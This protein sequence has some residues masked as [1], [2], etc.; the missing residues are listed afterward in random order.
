MNIHTMDLNLFLVFR[1]I[2]ETGSVTL[3]GDRVGL[4]QSAASNALR[5]MRERFGDPLFVRTPGGMVPTALAQRLIGPV[6][7]GLGKLAQ[8]LEE[9]AQFD[10]A[11]S[12]RTF[13]I[14]INDIG[15]LVMM[16]RLLAAANQA[17]PGVRFETVDAKLAE[18]RHAMVHGQVD[19]AVGS[20]R[21]M[22]PTF[23]QQRLFDETFV[24]LMSATHPL[25]GRAMRFEDYAAADHIAYRPSGSTDE[26]LQNALQRAG[27]LAQR[28]V[29]L[30][31]GHSLGL[32]AILAGS[33]MLLTAPSRLAHA[34]MAMCPDLHLAPLPFEVAPFGVRQQWHERFQHDGGN[35][36]LRTLFMTL[37]HQPSARQLVARAMATDPA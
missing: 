8:V 32:P 24:A 20:W 34:M 28:K 11:T 27:V 22:G 1:A 26:E 35:R 13:R 19:L 9:G 25:V 29:V 37:F 6:S 31:A 4:T 7:E 17:A 10:P 18:A 33:R 30:T 12:T 15:Q 2:Y 3:G 14:C 21:P 36:W 16:P 23:Y 5:R